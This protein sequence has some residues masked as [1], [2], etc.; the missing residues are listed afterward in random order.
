[1]KTQN[2]TKKNKHDMAISSLYH[3]LTHC[4]ILN[5]HNVR[6]CLSRLSSTT[7]IPLYN[8]HVLLEMI[9]NIQHNIKQTHHYISFYDIR[10]VDIVDYAE[11]HGMKITVIP[12]WID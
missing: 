6:Q 5:P 1:M 3:I 8:A 9:Y 11:E 12:H 2:W 10:D 4:L 7:L